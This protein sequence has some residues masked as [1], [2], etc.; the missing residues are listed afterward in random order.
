MAL[1]GETTGHRT[2]VESGGAGDPGTSPASASDLDASG[3]REFLAPSRARRQHEIDGLRA[4]AVTLIVFHHSFTASLLGSPSPKSAGSLFSATTT[5]GVELFFVLSGALLLRPYLRDHRAFAPLKYLRRRVERLWPPYLAALAFAGLVFLV[6]T[7]WPTWYSREVLKPFSPTDWVAQAGILNFGWTTYSGAWW[8][9]T[10][11]VLFYLL[12]PLVVVVA[13]WCHSRARRVLA[14][15]M[16][17]LASLLAVGAASPDWPAVAALAALFAPCFIV[18]ALLARYSPGRLVGVTLVTIGLIYVL[19]ANW[20]PRAD[21]HLGFALLYGGVF[22]LA[23]APSTLLNRSLSKPRMVWLGER[24]YSLF[25]V[26]FPAFYFANWIASLLF[27][28]R[29]T[30]YFFLTRAT[31]LPLAMLVAMVIFWMIERRYARGL[32]TAGSFWPSTHLNA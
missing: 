20:W 28:R 26:H 6:A 32:A 18:G 8:S 12:V 31:G 1:G 16:I 5:S 9:L 27:A 30:S 24:S 10:I 19:V 2:P 11:E 29:T 23:T 21:I 15:S 13:V 17:G 3:R 25:L 22:I 4:V 7:V 14:G